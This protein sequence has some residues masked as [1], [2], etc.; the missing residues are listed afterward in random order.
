MESTT[1]FVF[2]YMLFRD[3]GCINVLCKVFSVR[4]IAQMIH[5]NFQSSTLGHV[6]YVHEVTLRD[7]FLYLNYSA[8]YFS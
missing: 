1:H 2:H 7:V 8:N 4:T 6:G 3:T 5:R